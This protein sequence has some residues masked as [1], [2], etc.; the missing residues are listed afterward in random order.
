MK[1]NFS[2]RLIVGTDF[3]SLEPGKAVSALEFERPKYGPDGSDRLTLRD[4]IL[5]A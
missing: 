5:S 3:S 4:S 2:R 1:L